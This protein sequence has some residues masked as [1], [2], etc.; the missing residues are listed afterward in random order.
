[1]ILSGHFANTT[2]VFEIV[3]VGLSPVMEYFIL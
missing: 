3:T 1:M 2:L